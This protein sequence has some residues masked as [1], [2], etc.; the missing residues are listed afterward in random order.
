MVNANHFNHFSTTFY[1]VSD[2]Q[3]ML[4]PFPYLRCFAKLLNCLPEDEK[5]FLTDEN[6]LSF[7]NREFFLITSR[8]VGNRN[9]IFSG[10]CELYISG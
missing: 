1:H 9:A 7:F 2:I 10:R 6:T 8:R 5:S 4:K 3:K